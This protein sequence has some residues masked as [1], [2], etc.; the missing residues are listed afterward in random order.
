[1]PLGTVKNKLFRARQMLKGVLEP[2][3]PEGARAGR[4]RPWTTIVTANGS[5]CAIDGALD[6]SERAGLAAHLAGCADCRA[7]EARLRGLSARL[8][9]SLAPVRPG[10]AA[11][12]MSALEPAPWEA[13]T[14]RAWRLPFALLLALGGAA[15]AL[16]GGAAAGLDP[17]ARSLG[18]F[19]ALADLFGA[20]LVAGGG[21]AAASWHGLGL[22]VGE[23]LVGLARQPGG[24]RGR[25]GRAQLPPLSPA[26][27]RRAAGRG[28]GGAIGALMTSRRARALALG[29]ALAGAA[30]RSGPS[31]GPTAP[32]RRSPRR[33]ILEA[34]AVA[35]HQIVAIGRDVL[36]AGRGARGRGGAR[37][38]G[39]RRRAACAAT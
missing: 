38:L 4:K 8:A 23:W 26:A 34:G 6:D 3:A 2:E 31:R 16:F 22:G 33:C 5:I 14:L 20:A 18:A 35:R 7:E 21:L 13:R 36:V 12:V 39:A 30:G 29:L 1:M 15:A 11:E 9:G 27:P 24:G 28:A 17:G 32:A 37:R 19:L 10:F 25:A